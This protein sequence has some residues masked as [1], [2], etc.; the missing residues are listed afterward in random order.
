MKPCEYFKSR[1]FLTI[2]AAIKADQPELCKFKKA[3]VSEYISAAVN[4]FAELSDT[5]I[6][7]SVNALIVQRIIKAGY[8]LKP[9]DI[10]YFFYRL[11][12]GK[13]YPKPTGQTILHE[14]ENYLTERME[15][16]ASQSLEKHNQNKF[17][18]GYFPEAGLKSGV[19]NLG[20]A[21][22]ELSNKV[23]KW[24][25]NNGSVPNLNDNAKDDTNH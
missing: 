7:G 10:N 21:V 14:F 23:E 8:Y 15:T 6:P 19:M 13:W 11:S 4:T 1:D 12:V 20:H 17:T 22:S 3:E 24:Q 16:A 9:A 5:I 25:Q 18:Q 2:S